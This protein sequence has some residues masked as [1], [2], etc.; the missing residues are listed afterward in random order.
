MFSRWLDDHSKNAIDVPFITADQP[1]INI[2]AKPEETKPPDKFELYYP[3]ST[4]KATLP[5]EPRSNH[6]PGSRFVSAILAHHYNL[7][8]GAHAYEQI[9]ANSREELESVRGES[10]AFRSCL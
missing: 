10:R 5:V 6:L 3:L 1:V 4:N 7:L 8:M 2:A 9:F